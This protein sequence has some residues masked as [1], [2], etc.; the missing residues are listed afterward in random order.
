MK[1]SNI[2]PGLTEET[3]SVY[4]RISKLNCITNLVLCGGTAISL[5]CNH[6]LSEDLDFELVST[7]KID[8]SL[9]FDRIINEVNA[10][11]PGT[12]KEILGEDH[13]ELFLPNG[14]KL[15]FFKPGKPLPSL[16]ISYKYNN[17]KAPS[18]QELLGMKLFTISVRTKFRDYY[19]IYTLIKEGYDFQEGIK[20]A[21]NFSR[22]TLH[23]K[24]IYTI[25][26]A[27]SFFKKEK[28]FDIELSPRYHVSSEEISGLFKKIIKEQKPPLST[29]TNKTMSRHR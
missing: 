29:K 19:D 22:H 3:A 10:E 26:M 23:T 1:A 28:E 18:L 20:Y 13:F 6:R 9:Q 2:I 15:S 11:F 17:I 7:K 12:K 21:C 24:D 25:L 14:V 8:E 27:P 5:Q 4:E 16:N